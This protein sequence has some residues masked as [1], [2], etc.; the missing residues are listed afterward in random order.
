MSD[1]WFHHQSHIPPRD[2]VVAG[3]EAD[4][5]R[6]WVARYALMEHLVTDARMLALWNGWLAGELGARS[7]SSMAAFQALAVQRGLADRSQLWSAEVGHLGGALGPGVTEAES[8]AL[9]ERLEAAIAAWNAVRAR[10]APRMLDDTMRLVVEDWGLPWVW[11][12]F[13]LLEVFN[14]TILSAI[15]GMAAIT[16]VAPFV[17]DPPAPAVRVAFEPAAGETA[18]QA[19]VRLRAETARA[20]AALTPP[21]PPALPR[22]YRP[23]TEVT[24]RHVAWFYRHRVQGESIKHIHR[25]D[26]ADRATVRHGIAEAERLLSLTPF[27]WERVD[28]AK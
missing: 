2:T 19:R 21:A 5:E 9:G 18:S 7:Y 23:A 1:H 10:E 17:P 13:E 3:T 8:R 24:Q 16:Q 14:T 27:H 28:G 22:G 20:M 15:L 12:E 4:H 26:F 11:L 6:H 25:V